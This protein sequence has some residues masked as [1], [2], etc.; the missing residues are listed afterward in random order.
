MEL[1]IIQIVGIGISKWKFDWNI[2]HG[3]LT[4]KRKMR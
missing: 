2:E 3:S 1:S 4:R